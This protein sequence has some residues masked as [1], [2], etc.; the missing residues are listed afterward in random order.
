MRKLTIICTLAVMLL[1]A[2]LAEAGWEE[3]VAA[4]KAGNLS[5]A[6]Q[7]FQGVVEGS[8][9]FAGGHFMLGQV[10]LKQ[11]KSNEALTH[12]RKAYE[13]EPDNIGHQMALGQAYLNNR[14]F[15]DAAQ[16][17][18]RINAASLPKPQQTVYY[19]MLGAAL[20]ASGDAAGA[21][22]A[23]KR[24]AEANP[25]DADAWFRYGSAAY[26]AGQTDAGVAALEKAVKLDGNDAAKRKAYT[27]ALVRQARLA[28]GNTKQAA[29]TKAVAAAGALARMD[30]S[31]DNLLLLG[32]VQLGAKQ[33]QDAVASLRQATSKSGNDWHP[34]FYLSQAYTQLDQWNA[35][36]TSAQAAL[37][38][39][40]DETTR[41]R[42]WRQIG[43]AY[44]KQKSFD[45]AIDAYQKA[46]DSA[47]VERVAENKRIAEENKGI[48]QENAEIARMEEERRRLEK[49]LQELDGPPRR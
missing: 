34:H 35:A 24:V 19:Q 20:Q 42:V 44:E 26:N 40:K 1:A 48:E 33:Y 22:D 25:N 12:L 39:A 16:I 21:L 29:Y 45:Q 32:E 49:E 27:Q 28:R 7:E 46:G 23:M 36:A 17:L 5:A 15:D 10:L 37:E 4:Y 2:G 31:Y 3:G 47:S 30:G 8:P 18:K 9:E 41:Q 13:L 14:R 6:A 11:K 38:R 43:F